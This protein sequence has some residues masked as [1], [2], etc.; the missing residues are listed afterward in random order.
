MI[1]RTI[2]T[3][4]LPLAA[5]GAVT[6]LAE[7][8]AGAQNARCEAAARNGTTA[9]TNSRMCQVAPSTPSAPGMETA[10][11]DDGPAQVLT[12]DPAGRLPGAHTPDGFVWVERN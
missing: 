12:Y 4:L 1:R 6:L 10:P 11:L 5:A 8:T 2:A 9:V 3:A 7:G